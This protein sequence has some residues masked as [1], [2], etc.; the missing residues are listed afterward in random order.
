[1]ASKE[2]SKLNCP[3]VLSNVSMLILRNH[4]YLCI[5]SPLFDFALFYHHAPSLLAWTNLTNKLMQM[6]TGDWYVIMCHINKRVLQDS[7]PFSPLWKDTFMGK[8]HKIEDGKCVCRSSLLFSY[9][10]KELFFYSSLYRMKVIFNES[11]FVQT[12]KNLC[13]FVILW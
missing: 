2:K 4:T 10:K 12:F 5:P 3:N 1:M 8:I 11:L 7:G 6:H 13:F 9:L